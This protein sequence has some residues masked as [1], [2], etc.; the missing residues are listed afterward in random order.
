MTQAEEG[1][2]KVQ[3]VLNTLDDLRGKVFG[4]LTVVERVENDRF[5]TVY[6]LCRCTC[7]E[8]T[9]RRGNT[10]RAG[11]FFTC[12]AQACRFWEKVQKQPGEGCWEWT[13]GLRDDGYGAMKVPG[14]QE[15]ARAHVYSWELHNGPTNGLWVLHNCD[16]RRCI[17]P[18][19]LFLGTHQDNM[20]D[21]LCKGRGARKEDKKHL[22]REEALQMLADSVSGQSYPQLATKYGV[23]TKTVGR[24]LKVLR[25]S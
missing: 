16:N 17:R 8:L 22:S 7:G 15:V 14:S 1:K 2:K 5:G 6:W 13:G 25:T 19:H 3:T 11:K 24:W 23:T 12:G 9:R 4:L 21:M 20:T 18:D 10:L